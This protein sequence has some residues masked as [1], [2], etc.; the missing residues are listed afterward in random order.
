MSAWFSKLDMAVIQMKQCC[1]RAATR[2]GSDHV[3][4]PILISIQPL[5][6][7]FAEKRLTNL[8][9]SHDV[10]KNS[11]KLI[12]TPKIEIAWVKGS[13]LPQI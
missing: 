11:A 9:R 7:E 6:I 13:K 4:N 12:S 3:S 1:Y 5:N 2:I 10:T 8:C